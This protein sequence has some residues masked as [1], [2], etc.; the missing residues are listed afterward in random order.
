MELL[1]IFG[2]TIPPSLAVGIV[3]WFRLGKLIERLI[4]A[5]ERAKTASDGAL[6][7]HQRIDALRATQHHTRL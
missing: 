2:P 7:A 3:V 4:L 6:R 1:A 5:E